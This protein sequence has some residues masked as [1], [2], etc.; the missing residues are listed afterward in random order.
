MDGKLGTEQ[1]DELEESAKHKHYCKDVVD[2]NTTN[3]A[4]GEQ[5]QLKGADGTADGRITTPLHSSFQLC[6]ASDETLQSSFSNSFIALSVSPCLFSRGTGNLQCVGSTTSINSHGF[7]FCR[8]CYDSNESS[9]NVALDSRGRLIAPCLCDGSL[10]YVHEKCIQDWFEISESRMCEVCHFVYEMRK[11]MK[12]LREWEDLHGIFCT[13]FANL[14]MQ[15]FVSWMLYALLSLLTPAFTSAS[16]C[17]FVLWLLMLAMPFVAFGVGVFVFNQV[18]SFCEMYRYCR[19]LN[20]VCVVREPSE[21]RIAKLRMER[22]LSSN[23]FY[24]VHEE[25]TFTA[26]P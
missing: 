25:D 12:P 2:C 18:H 21:E 14:L 13:V 5:K 15:A 7:P 16:K 23:Q 17:S 4:E 22:R 9:K 8:I 11:C 20:W 3:V 26:M 6:A 1:M 24:T 19:Q 10:K